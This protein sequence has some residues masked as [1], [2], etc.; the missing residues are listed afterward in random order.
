M[1]VFNA[2]AIQTQN[3]VVGPTGTYLTELVLCILAAVVV[4][5]FELPRRAG[6]TVPSLSSGLAGCTKI[7]KTCGPEIAGVVACLALA[8]M[9]RAKGEGDMQLDATTAAAWEDIKS[10]WPLLLTADTLLSLQAMLRFVA[11]LSMTLRS[12]RN[13]AAAV[14]LADEVATLALG[15]YCVRAAVLAVTPA[16]MLDGPLGGN[17]P[18]GFDVVA[19]PLLVGRGGLK[20]IWRCPFAVL[21]VVCV[22]ALLANRHFLALSGDG[23]F[24]FVTKH[25]SSLADKLFISAHLLETGAAFMYLARSFLH[26]SEREGIVPS[27]WAS[28]GFTHLLMTAQQ[29]LAAYF[30]FFAFDEAPELV[31]AGCPFKVLQLCNTASLGAYACTAAVFIVECFEYGAAAGAGLF[32]NAASPPTRREDA[33]T[34]AS[35]GGAAS[36]AH[37]MVL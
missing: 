7:L 1:A 30:F 11:L 35:D 6:D 17:L 21:A 22:V 9:L 24:Q 37:A 29:S 34:Q 10:K 14:P 32:V 31:G 28:V 8:A 20:F 3:V 13:A 15:A 27:A 16:Y 36:H 23:H 2:Y 18:A 12:R 26:G 5:R 25:F 4:L 19:I 33:P